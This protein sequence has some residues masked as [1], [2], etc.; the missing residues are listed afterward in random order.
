M[1]K[2]GRNPAGNDSFFLK[3]HLRIPDRDN[4]EHTNKHFKDWKGKKEKKK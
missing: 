3:T 4:I 1:P 2:L